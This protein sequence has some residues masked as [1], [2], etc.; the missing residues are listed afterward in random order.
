MISIVASILRFAYRT[1]LLI[2]FLLF[3]LM[4][5]LMLVNHYRRLEQEAGSRKADIAGMRLGTRLA[6]LFG[7]R[8][9]VTGKPA[10]GAVLIAANHISWLDIPVLHSACAMS[11]VA[12]AEIE[13]WPVFNYI[14][15]T[16]STI[17]HHD[18]NGFLIF[19]PI[20][21]RRPTVTSY[22]IV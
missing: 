9:Q 2:G 12:K 5:S 15:S 14:A 1:I 20:L 7:I 19:I 17:F 11:F 18:H 6:G 21:R 8:V 22:A 4:P 13:S 16:G 10:D 3:L